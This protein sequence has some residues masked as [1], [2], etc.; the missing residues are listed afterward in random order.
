M[1][2]NQ[3]DK[4]VAIIGGGP[5]GLVAAKSL[6]EEGLQ[7]TIFEQ[8][9][10]IGGQWNAPAAHSGV[11]KAMR[12]NT[13]KVTMCF[14]GLPFEEELP[15]FLTNQQAHA[16]LLKYAKQF[17]LNERVRLN[18]KVKMISRA[19]DGG[20]SVESTTLGERRETEPFSHVIIASG[21]FNKP[22]IPQLRGLERFA[23]AIS[24]TF[25]YRSNE[26]F[27]GKRVLVIGNGISGLEVAS[28]L[29]NDPTV[30]VLSSC[31]KPRY[32]MLRY[33]AVFRQTAFLHALARCLIVPSPPKGRRKPSKISSLSNAAAPNSTED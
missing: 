22:R 3:N 2:T 19:H 13:S 18:N 31:R 9:S 11:W 21:R 8:S 17:G 25:D 32:I 6:L 20:W 7:P 29:D 24:H 15:M 30:T 14:S 1:R 5:A 10:N 27:K 4:R 26:D 16:Y 23:G 12:A 33:L 28:E